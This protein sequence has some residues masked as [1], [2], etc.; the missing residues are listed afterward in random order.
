MPELLTGDEAWIGLLREVAPLKNQ[1]ND[2]AGP[3]ERDSRAPM[4]YFDQKRM[5]MWAA[6]MISYF[7]F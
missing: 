7:L 1:H 3:A 4:R 6:P 2:S 5:I